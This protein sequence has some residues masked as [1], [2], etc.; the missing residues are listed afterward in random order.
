MSND[1][2]TIEHFAL[3]RKRRYRYRY[4]IWFLVFLAVVAIGLGIYMG[5]VRKSQ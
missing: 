2:D 5:I 1:N 3:F 4:K